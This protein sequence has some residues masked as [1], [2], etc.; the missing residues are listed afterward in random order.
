MQKFLT[1]RK[2]LVCASFACWMMCS[3]LAIAQTASDTEF[4]KTLEKTDAQFFL[5]QAEAPNYLMPTTWSVEKGP[6]PRK[7]A[8]GTGLEMTALCVAESHGWIDRKTA[9]DRITKILT[10]VA[11]QQAAHPETMGLMYHYMNP[12]GSRYKTSNVGTDDGSK[13]ILGALVARQYFHD[14]AITQLVD[15]IYAAVD[16]NAWINPKNDKAYEA[17]D[18]EKGFSRS[19]WGRYSEGPLQVY[20]LGMG[21][22]VPRHALTL[23]HWNSWKR[24][25][26]NHYGTDPV[27]TWIG[28]S[29]ALFPQQYPQIFFDLRGLKDHSPEGNGVSYWDNSIQAT[30]AQWQWSSDL[31]AGAVNGVGPFPHWG[32]NL[33]GLTATASQS[34][35][36]N[37]WGG[38]LPSDPPPDGTLT[39]A[40][41]GGSLPF[42]PEQSLHTLQYMKAHYPKTW[43]R[44]G[45]VEAFNPENDWYAQQLSTNQTGV[46]LL[47]AENLTTGLVWRSF[48]S[49]PEIV[50]ALKVAQM[51]K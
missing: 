46:T 41:A 3:A 4:L 35:S 32:V 8:G 19:Q 37:T 10:V 7:S 13:L 17:W 34:G 28:A 20:L 16:W 40:A 51:S 43:F 48:M 25:P 42:T 27:Y 29:P 31:G 44:Y 21:S 5:D 23:K 14:P 2:L 47:M 30:L 12:D 22:P 45:F 38:P 24:G 11:R 15:R 1:T 36:F 33:W 39:P 6:D 50:K 49:S 9:I 26:V 18:P